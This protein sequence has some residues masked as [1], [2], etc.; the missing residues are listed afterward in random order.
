LEKKGGFEV[1]MTKKEKFPIGFLL[2]GA[3]L[4]LLCLG[5]HSNK[6][7]EKS[8]C[9]FPQ[10]CQT[11]EIEGKIY[12]L[13]IA[14]TIKSRTKGLMNRKFLGKNQGMLFIFPEEGNYSFWMFQTKIPLKIIWLDK[15]WKVVHT[16][17]KAIP[18]QEVNPLKC[19]TYSSPKPAKYV[20]EIN[21]KD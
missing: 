3:F 10:K 16:E 14:D 21:P 20:V 9:L 11:L 19:P 7:N 18:C 5:R 6:L 15:N 1:K 13:R 2:G 8:Y 17:N 12:Q 4:L